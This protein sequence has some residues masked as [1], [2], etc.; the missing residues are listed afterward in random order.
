M[1]LMSVRAPLKLLGT[2][3]RHTQNQVLPIKTTEE[4]DKNQLQ[5]FFFK[6]K[7]TFLGVYPASMLGVQ[8]KV[9]RHGVTS[10]VKQHLI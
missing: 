2:G 4:L 7:T 3:K 5:L 6:Y 8:H 9:L 1:R 10:D